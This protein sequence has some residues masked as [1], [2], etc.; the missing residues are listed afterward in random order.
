MIHDDTTKVVYP[1]NHAFIEHEPVAAMPALEKCKEVDAKHRGFPPRREDLLGEHLPQE[2]EVADDD[3][4]HLDQV[5]GEYVAV[6]KMKVSSG[7]P[8]S[9][10]SRLICEISFL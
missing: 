5:E 6:P 10:I 1:Y 8:L 7:F 3:L 4:V 2:F 9:L